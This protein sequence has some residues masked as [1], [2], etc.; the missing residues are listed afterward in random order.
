MIKTIFTGSDPQQAVREE[1]EKHDVVHVV[2]TTV[3]SDPEKFYYDICLYLG[4]PFCMEEDLSTG[5]KT[6]QFWT[7]I[8]YTP[9]ITNSF[10]H[11]NC[12][13]P[14]HTDGSYES[15]AP[16]ISFFYCIE[17]A[18]YGGSTIFVDR[19]T[20]LKCLEI[21]DANLLRELQTH[22]LLFSKGND[23]KRRLIIG[24]NHLNWNYYRVEHNEL[25]EKFHLFLQKVIVDGGIYEPVN[26]RPN[27]AIFFWDERVLHGRTSYLGK[28][29]LRKGGVKWM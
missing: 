1:L 27:E 21:Y 5:N 22:Q 3:I 23:S 14:L 2:P 12:A 15:A 29:W 20:L 18:R 16:D 8:K 25:T 7:D 17:K 4:E 6:K 9:E 24:E 10:R 11:A 28:R 13:Q 19:H 26:L